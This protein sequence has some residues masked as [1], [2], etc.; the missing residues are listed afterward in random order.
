MQQSNLADS[1]VNADV[2]PAQ[3]H[4]LLQLQGLMEV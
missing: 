3:S 2:I 1:D 4:V